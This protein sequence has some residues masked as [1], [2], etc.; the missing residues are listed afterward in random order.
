M[1]PIPASSTRAPTPLRNASSQDRKSTRLNSS[2]MSISYAVFCLIPPPPLSPPFP[3][4]TLFRSTPRRRPRR[5]PPDVLSI[6]CIER[7]CS[8]RLELEVLVGRRVGLV[9]DEADPRLFHPG[10]HAVEERK[11]PRS[12]EHTSE[13][14]SHVNLVCRLLL[15]TSSPAL[16]TLSLHDALPIYAQAASTA[17]ST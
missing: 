14:Q 2:H 11:L 17:P 1:R 4:T 6:G 5:P 7:W 16:S 12:E 9:L 13:L 10:P 3:Y 15:D 8:L